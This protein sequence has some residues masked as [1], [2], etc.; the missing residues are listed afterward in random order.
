[1]KKGIAT[2]KYTIIIGLMVF[3]IAGYFV[4]GSKQSAAMEDAIV[5][6]KRSTTQ[7]VATSLDFDTRSL[8]L[9]ENPSLVNR[10]MEGG[11]FGNE[12]FS[13]SAA[14]TMFG[15]DDDAIND[16]IEKTYVEKVTN[17]V[18]TIHLPIVNCSVVKT[19]EGL[20][21]IDTG[22]KPAGPAILKSIESISKR[23]IHTII[24]T[25][26]H[27]D[28]AYGTWALLENGNN[29][30]IIAHENLPDRFNRY[31]K[32]RGSLAKYMSQPREQLPRDSSDFI[33]PTKTFED[34]LELNIGGVV[35][36]LTHFEGETDDQLF[37]WLPAQKIIFAADYYKG[38]LPN[39][40]NGKRVQ[41]NIGSWIEALRFMVTLEPAIMVPSHGEI[42]YGKQEIS[43]ALSIHAD[44]LAYIHDYTVS[45]LNKGLRKDLIVNQF[46]MPDT[47]ANHP[48][49]KE[50][51]VSAKD[52]SKMVI[53]QYTG[54]WDGIPSHWSPATIEAQAKSIVEI[55]GGMDKL[56]NHIKNLIPYDLALASHFV[57]WAYY[58]EPDNKEVQ[59]L[60]LEVYKNR[61]LDE[62][63]M[64]QEM[65]VY[66]DQMTEIRAKMQ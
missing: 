43:D 50:Q 55:S 34:V 1:M 33:W 40:G 27:V 12:N 35:F 24:Y 58:A 45:A 52:I 59:E 47:F 44:A 20:V 62:N 36:E 53:A 21:I 3:F 66:L 48:L 60:V 32:L 4:G 51:Y 54:W 41:R 29:P 25:H 64:T 17:D 57:D 63:S 15:K 6:L 37:V 11:S 31:V 65:L 56:I 13:V 14:Q 18:W 16:I 8:V 49:L 61:I 22:M 9:M 39:A 7:A 28:H 23:K 30:E 2:S 19:N 46:I 42:V 26:G 5:S 38:F 10:I